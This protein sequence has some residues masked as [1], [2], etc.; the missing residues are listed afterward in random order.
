MTF[1][2]LRPVS[3]WHRR[4]FSELCLLHCK[5][6]PAIEGLEPRIVLDSTVVLNEVMFHAAN[7]STLEWIELF[8]QNS[9]NMDL[10][11]W[12]LADETNFTFPEGTV[13][14]GRGF[15]VIA[16]D[17][18]SL[19]SQ[20]GVASVLG[21]LV[22]RLSNGG[23]NIELRDR[24]DRLMDQVDY[25]DKDDWPVAP[26][27]GGVTL[28]KLDADMS[29]M[30][31]EN[32]AFSQFVD[33]T[34]GAVNF[35]DS[36]FAHILPEATVSYWNLDAEGVRVLDQA[37]ENDGV[38]GS[39]ASRASGLVGPGSIALDGT[40]NAYVSLGPGQDDSL[41][42]REAIS[43]EATFTSN[44]DGAGQATLL[45]KNGRPLEPS[46]Y[47]SFDEANQPDDAAPV[48]LVGV[49][50]GTFVG[51][52]TYA[53]GLRGFGAARLTGGDE[54][55]VKL[56][57]PFPPRTQRNVGGDAFIFSEGVTL[58]AIIMPGAGLGSQP[59]HTIFHKDDGDDRIQLAIQNSGA[60]I[61]FGINVGSGFS[62]L[63]M[64]L[65]GQEGRPALSDL[66]DGAAHHLAAV[67]DADSGFQGIYVDGSL[68]FSVIAGAGIPMVSGGRGEARI[69]S[70][71][72]QT[73]VFDGVIDDFAIW[74]VALTADDISAL[75]AGSSPL[76]L[77]DDSSL[78]PGN[79]IVLS[80]QSDGNNGQAV[81]PVADGPVLSF[82]LTVGNTY[83]ELDMPLDG[84]EGRPML[85]QLTDGLPHHVVASYDAA[86]D[87]KLLRIDGTVKYSTP[88][89]GAPLSGKSLSATINSAGAGQ[90]VLGN[91]QLGGADPF[92]GVIDEVAVYDRVLT[93]EEAN[94]HAKRALAAENY[95][96]TGLL[97]YRGYVLLNEV[98]SATADSFFVELIN[99]AN[100]TINLSG[101]A[102]ASGD[103]GRYLVPV[104]TEL[105]PQGVVTFAEADLGFSI[106][107][108]EK[109]FV[110]SADN[111]S[112]ADAVVVDDL[113]RGRSDAYPEQWL[114]PEVPTPGGPNH[115]VLNQDVVINEIQ[116]HPLAV[117]ERPA[118]VEESIIID[119]DSVWDFDD[120]GIAPPS[121]WNQPDFQP[122]GWSYGST[123]MGHGFPTQYSQ[124]I[125][126]D[127]PLAYWPLGDEGDVAVDLTG[128]GHNGV[129]DAG[130]T[131][132]QTDLVGVNTD[133]A[134]RTTGNSRIVVPG[135]E[136]F[137]EGSTGYTAEYWITIHKPPRR[138]HNIVGDGEGRNDFY[139]TN[140]LSRDGRIST[141]S[142]TKEVVLNSK[143]S[144]LKL[145][146]GQTY[147]VVT[148]YDPGRLRGE[149]YVNGQR[150]EVIGLTQ[151]LP[152]NTDNPIYI[153]KDDRGSSGDITVDEVAIYNYPLSERQIQEHYAAAGLAATTEVDGNRSSV[154]LRHEFSIE[155]PVD[156]TN[157]ILD[158]TV[159][160]AALVYL[161]GQ[162]V[163]R[164]NIVAGSTDASMLAEQ[165]VRIPLE[166]ESIDIPTAAL[167]PGNNV[168]AVQLIQQQDDA[169]MLFTAKLRAVKTMAPAVE[170]SESDE[171]WIELYNVGDQTVD[172][173][174]W[175]FSDAVR[176]TFAEGTQLAPGQFLVVARDVA[177]LQANYGGIPVVG[178]YRGRLSDSNE[179]IV[180]S[181]AIGNPADIVHYYD[182]GRW[183]GNADGW[184]ASLE[185]IDPQADNSAAEMW[186]AS[187]EARRSVW[188]TISY[189]GIADNGLHKPDLFHEFL[190]GLLGRGEVLIDDVRVIQDP[191]GAAISLIQ[192]GGFE[193]DEL[194]STPAKWRGVGNHHGVVVADP[195]D[196]NNHVLHITTSGSTKSKHDIAETTLKDGDTFVDL[197]DGAEYAISL[198]AKWLSGSNRLN[199]RLYYNRLPRTTLLET[200][201]FSGTPGAP[202][203]RWQV[204]TGPTYQNLSHAPVQPVPGQDMSIVVHAS[205][206][207]GV[208]YVTLWYAVNEG[209]W[210]NLRM[211]ADGLGSYTATLRAGDSGDL[212]QFYIEGID[213]LG[214]TTTFPA[215]GPDSR[216]LI[217]VDAA[218]QSAAPLQ[219]M[220]ILMTADDVAF[221]FDQTQ[222]DS[223]LRL[224]AT[225][226]HEDQVF[227]D[228]GVRL[229]GNFTRRRDIDRGFSIKFHADDLFRGVHEKITIDRTPIEIFVQ[230]IF[231][232]A[233]DVPNMYNDVV[234]VK[235]PGAVP[236]GALLQMARF[237]EVYLDSQFADGAD[238]PVYNYDSVYYPVRTVDR[239]PE[240]LKDFIENSNR[241][242][243]TDLGDDKEDYRYNFQLRYGRRPDNFAPMIAMAKLFDLTG[244]EFLA[245]AD[246]ILDVDQWLRAFAVAQLVG[247]GDSYFTSQVGMSHNVRFYQRP[248][249]GRIL[250]F[251]WDLDAAFTV[252]VDLVG[253]TDLAKLISR[254][255][256]LHHYYGHVYDIA[257]TTMRTDYVEPWL[258]HFDSLFHNFP[259]LLDDV[260]R[261][262]DQALEQV[263]E[264]APLVEFAIIEPTD[265]ELTVEQSTVTVMGNGWVN[266]R[267]IRL[268]GSAHPLDV[269]WN[270]VTQW[271]TTI[272][273]GQ[274]ATPFTF[275]AFDYQGNRVGSDTI[276]VSSSV[277]AGDFDGSGNTDASDIDLL[278]A[279]I[280]EGN[281]KPRFDLNHDSVVNQ[282]D[283]DELI[284]NILGTK[285][286]DSNLD[287]RVDALDFENLASH[288][289]AA[290]AGWR[291][292][293][294][295]GDGKVTFADFTQLSNS[296]GFER[297]EAA[298]GE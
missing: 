198:R 281:Q 18:A 33:G 205:D 116:Y 29:A 256:N 249:D 70:S 295:D 38:L 204:N 88:L 288:F 41:R 180:L 258:E 3:S 221:L 261:N 203:S 191:Q 89:L 222:Q 176:F 4:R 79:R 120:S 24:N 147:H 223:N 22:G 69:G 32:W 64:P 111:R 293:D 138:S 8:N 235:A 206:P 21:P 50:N 28:A 16:N 76:E 87:T 175:S 296:F 177:T 253:H 122:E 104:G 136:K 80:F 144:G 130:V 276:T 164:H 121:E 229:K 156:D 135:F 215:A 161:N 85:A 273:V 294:F 54:D 254:P 232:H 248:A 247:Q 266:V 242:P 217:Q 100:E 102:I 237:E 17:P 292:G 257:M 58:Q 101:M 148:V 30:P 26:D 127:N 233:G 212:L 1:D 192:N 165:P 14:P 109:L 95:F 46:G 72:G 275:E 244:D 125:L 250:I 92:H 200:P 71:A 106:R 277:T 48:D 105:A 2:R 168:L 226:V 202:N 260:Q 153:G 119:S 65:D 81:P 246:K 74:P 44:W 124:L 290:P 155:D 90:A 132:G 162:E 133:G 151:D 181:D 218:V 86:T 158:L 51:G 49:N 186:M 166:M 110:Q 231:G 36:K 216:A 251:P 225:V 195:N 82:G 63:S 197:Q 10:S 230:Q 238:G 285:Y 34:P 268:A 35:P 20:T 37:G 77:R 234:H 178:D 31:A 45:Q 150:D 141:N 11:S 140:Y 83:S 227:Y 129:I 52:A 91:S 118:V 170:Y 7:D 94:L 210:V 9:V 139:V 265:N 282:Q 187:D 214:A 61:D 53:D 131:K 241:I 149:I 259:K 167:R 23:G 143:A 134:V 267:E 209:P 152:Q 62:E 224:G 142:P 145:N 213:S 239:D 84:L 291:D 228:V 108:G 57:G 219:Q 272:P 190:L 75:S 40:E 174:G 97:S 279:S 159:D 236:G 263:N 123:P 211:A 184:G 56:G 208:E 43:I 146:V 189:A 286:G 287:G 60:S 183:D 157:L 115:F 5:R 207:D 274:T 126:N 39:G 196:K 283:V 245:Q 59:T 252:S 96:D 113:L 264:F 15:L 188:Q 27:G 99:P 98:A 13:I 169:D 67:Y 114:Y 6:C 298:N 262:A 194:G 269:T 185:L 172:L 117:H 103:G 255:D 289:G 243:F 182:S 137:P 278:F 68:R 73:D 163:F 179:R 270:T 240:G 154:Y 55:Y 220:Q 12:R 93:E 107:T 128:N 78:S 19:Q 284:L 297:D 171:E 47:W 42:F 66:K 271:Q 199:T 160:D 193:S 173:T 112:I 25:D 201:Q 280:T